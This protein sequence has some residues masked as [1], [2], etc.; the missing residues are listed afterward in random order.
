MKKL[1]HNE[2][3][4]DFWGKKKII[5][6]GC[7]DL[8]GGG[9]GEDVQHPR[10]LLT[11]ELLFWAFMTPWRISLTPIPILLVLLFLFSEP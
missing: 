5:L 11:C 2:I 8:L 4:S 3:G 6:G 7:L 9:K 10:K 1:C